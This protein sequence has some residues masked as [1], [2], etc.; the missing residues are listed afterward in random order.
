MH[1]LHILHIKL[2]HIPRRWWLWWIRRSFGARSY[3]KIGCKRSLTETFHLIWTMLKFCRHCLH[4]PFT[5]KSRTSDLSKQQVLPDTFCF[6]KLLRQ[7]QRREL[8]DQ[9]GLPMQIL[10]WK[11]TIDYEKAR[12]GFLILPCLK[13]KRFFFPALLG[14]QHVQPQRIFLVYSFTETPSPE[15]CPDD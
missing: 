7:H 2:F 15:P 12:D 11:K 14:P 8:W 10:D 5:C 13:W 1:K 3:W 9:Q 4:K 6:V